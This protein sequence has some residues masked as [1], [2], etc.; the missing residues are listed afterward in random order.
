MIGWGE[1]TRAGDADFSRGGG[2]GGGGDDGGGSGGGV[3]FGSSTDLG[4]A[5]AKRPQPLGKVRT[6]QT[7]RR[8]YL[9]GEGD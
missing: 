1:L 3:S 7:L 4:F 9:I 2:D 6:A 8:W 5:T